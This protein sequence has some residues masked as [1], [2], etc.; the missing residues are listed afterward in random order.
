[1][2]EPGVP[3]T[4]LLAAQPSSLGAAGADHS[5]SSPAMVEGLVFGRVCVGL[6][7]FVWWLLTRGE[8]DARI[9]D[10]YTLPSP[11]DTFASFR[12]LW[13]ERELSLSAMISLARVLGGFLLAAADRRSSRRH[14]RQLSAG[15][16]VSSSR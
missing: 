15:E 8:G 16:R 10:A 7:L 5:R 13:F 12:T 6:V 4:S 3:A 9:V 14:R 11:G 2:N 1:M